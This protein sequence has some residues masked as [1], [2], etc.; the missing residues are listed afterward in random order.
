MNSGHLENEHIQLRDI[1]KRGIALADANIVFVVFYFSVDY[2][3]WFGLNQAESQ[4]FGASSD[5]PAAVGKVVVYLLAA[6]AVLIPIQTFVDCVIARLLRK[7]VL[8]IRPDDGLL[9]A[10]TLK[11]FWLRMLLLNAIHVM[12]LTFA[13]PLYP[14]VYA[15]LR[16]VAAL[17]IWRDCSVRMGFS[18]LSAFLSVHL[19]KFVPVWIV[20][21]AV[22]IV[23]QFASRSPA[24][25]NPVFMGLVHLVGAYFD[26]A[27]VATALVSFIMLQKKQQEVPA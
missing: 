10:A 2:L 19:G 5:S 17:V 1:V 15:P 9:L 11:K 6:W 13:L 27:V 14:A 24:S 7:R 23:M 20:G 16:Y 18:G 3:T 21:T 4:L 8:G 22:W 12:I 26:F 25:A